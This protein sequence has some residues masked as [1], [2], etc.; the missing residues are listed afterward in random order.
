MSAAE[1]GFVELPDTFSVAEA[2]RK[3]SGHKSW[4]TRYVNKVSKSQPLLDRAYDRRTDKIVSENIRKAENEVAAMGMTPEFLVQKK[5]EKAKEHFKDVEALELEVA[6]AWDRYTTNIHNRAAVA[7]ATASPAAR[8]PPP[9]ADLNTVKL[10]TELK[11]DTLSH[12]A[13]AGELR[14][15]C[16]KY[17][18][19]YHA[20]NMQLA[21]NAAQHAYLLNCL[22]SEL[23]LLLTSAIA[24]TTPVLGAGASCLTMLANLFRQKYPLLLRKKTFFSM[25]QQSGQ[26]KRAFMESIKA[27]AGEADIQ[28]MNLED[29]LCLVCLTGL[30]DNRLREKLSEFETTTLPAFAV[31]IDAYMHSKATADS[32]AAVAAVVGRQQNKGGNRK[33]N[34]NNGNRPGLSD[35]EKKRRSVMKGK[36]SRCGSPDHMA[37]SCSVTKDIKCKKCNGVGHT[38]AACNALGQ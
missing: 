2:L 29:A 30:K 22:D 7:N 3:Y 10:R 14:I 37:N 27:A 17:E 36:C 18:A 1:T 33:N 9:P 35:N 15:W 21:S 8:R 32:S 34:N 31:L 25:E 23:Y 19:Y 16:R 38:Q 5:Y 12:D 26:E 4:S 13:S 11:P 28:G 20:S 6:A 24:A